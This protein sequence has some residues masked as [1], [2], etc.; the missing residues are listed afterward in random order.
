MGLPGDT[1]ETTNEH[2]SR[3]TH[4]SGGRRRGRG[5]HLVGWLCGMGHASQLPGLQRGNHRSDRRG[6]L[7]GQRVRPPRRPGSLPGLCGGGS[8]LDD[9][10]VALGFPHGRH[11][12]PGD[13]PTAFIAGKGCSLIRDRRSTWRE[14]SRVLVEQSWLERLLGVGRVR[15]ISEDGELTLSGLAQPRQVAAIVEH[16]VKEAKQQ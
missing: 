1:Q 10:A 11:Q 12:L 15:I 9:P 4:A 8:P 14:S 16:R 13:H 2:P 5:R 3:E 7:R 6:D